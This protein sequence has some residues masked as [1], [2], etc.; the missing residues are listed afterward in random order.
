[1]LQT[2]LQTIKKNKN[3]PKAYNVIGALVAVTCLTLYG[4]G[5]IT[6]DMEIFNWKSFGV[7]ASL[8]PF[9]FFCGGFS[10]T[11]VAKKFTK[12]SDG[13]KLS[14]TFITLA[15]ITAIVYTLV[16][17]VAT[18]IKNFSVANPVFLTVYAA[19]TW[20]LMVTSGTFTSLYCDV[21]EK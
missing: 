21:N 10:G 5:M 15:I 7:F 4:I 3:G 13:F 19:F 16:F 20:G 17:A 11:I 9:F 1:M 6:K 14:T 8:V 2:M 18:S 12:K